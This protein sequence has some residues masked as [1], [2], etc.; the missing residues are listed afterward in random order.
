M[1]IKQK[2]SHIP[3]DFFPLAQQLLQHSHLRLEGTR[4]H[5]ADGVLDLGALPTQIDLLDPLLAALLMLLGRRG[6]LELDLDKALAEEA[7]QKL[8]QVEPL[9]L[10]GGLFPLLSFEVGLEE[11]LSES[12]RRQYNYLAE[13]MLLLGDSPPR[14]QVM[15]RYSGWGGI[16]GSLN[17]YYTKPSLAKAMWRMILEVYSPTRVL[18][19]SCGVGVFLQ[20]APPN[21]ALEGVEIHPTSAKIA[22]RLFPQA[23]IHAQPFEAFHHQHPHR[24]FDCVLGNPPFGLRGYTRDGEKEY[25]RYFLKMALHHCQLGG[26]IALVLPAG[27]LRNQADQALRAEVLHKARVLAVFGLPNSAFFHAHTNA[28]T[29]DVWFLQRWHTP[30]HDPDFLAGNYHTAYPHLLLASNEKG[31]FNTRKGDYQEALAQLLRYRL[32]FQALD[33]QPNTPQTLDT[34]LNSPQTP[35]PL[36]KALGAKLDNLG[37]LQEAYNQAVI[38]GAE[39]QLY[40]EARLIHE[41]ARKDAYDH[42]VRRLNEYLHRFGNPNQT[43]HPLGPL[44]QLQ[45]IKAAL[46]DGVPHLEQGKDLGA[47]DALDLHSVMQML[48]RNGLKSRLENIAFYYRLGQTPGNSP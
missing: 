46:K 35:Q 47:Y 44:V 19:P 9:P 11:E 3:K 6:V 27:I 15:A 16:G 21:V 45:P 4:L 38:I 31:Y 22:Q 7:H 23:T 13:E 36:D 12:T 48:R 10:A 28:A 41:G 29:T 30:S 5:L 34:Q 33:T 39:L 14:L 26:I 25:A 2:Q 20:Y 37:P 8:Q 17:E 32:P 40:Q 24:L 1:T 18:E 43:L 42:L